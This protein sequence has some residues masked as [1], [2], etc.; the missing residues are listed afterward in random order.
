SATKRSAVRPGCFRYPR[1]NPAP[2]IYSSPLTPTGT[3]SKLLSSTYTRVFQIGFPMTEAPLSDS[4]LQ[5]IQVASM[6]ASVGPYR[7][8]SAAR[9]QA[10]NRSLKLLDKL[11][12][13]EKTLF[14]ESH[15][16]KLPVLSSSERREGTS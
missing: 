9:E 5:G 12:P 4:K 2:A 15:R 16:R 10:K 13:P 8:F 7:L 6:L 11:S 14:S 1:A 3:G